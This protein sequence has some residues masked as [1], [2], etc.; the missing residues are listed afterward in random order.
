[1]YCF[2]DVVISNSQT[3]IFGNDEHI[4][5]VRWDSDDNSNFYYDTLSFDK[6]LHFKH[7]IGIRAFHMS[8]NAYLY[9]SFEKFPSEAFASDCCIC[10]YSLQY[11]DDALVTNLLQSFD[12]DYRPL[13]INI[14]R[15]YIANFLMVSGDDC[16]VHTYTIDNGILLRDEDRGNLILL[17]A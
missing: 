15:S 11:S 14:L 7:M 12:L 10:V 6:P 17:N 5:Y 4:R 16:N 13:D 3:L 9:L 1:M 8:T 2:T